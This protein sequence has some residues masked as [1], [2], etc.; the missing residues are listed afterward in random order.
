MNSFW[1]VTCTEHLRWN[2][3]VQ[4]FWS[5]FFRR[6]VKNKWPHNRY[7][8]TV[9]HLAGVSEK[10]NWKVVLTHLKLRTWSSQYTVWGRADWCCCRWCWRILRCCRSLFC[11][12]QRFVILFGVLPGNLPSIQN[13][14]NDRNHQNDQKHG[15]QDLFLSWTSSFKRNFTIF[16]ATTIMFNTNAVSRINFFDVLGLRHVAMFIGNGI[17]CVDNTSDLLW[18]E[19]WVALML[20]EQLVQ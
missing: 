15:Q 1:N 4:G 17:F 11:Y 7:I 8:I 19:F 3:S 2:C 10:K 6:A 18:Y 16:E 13:D 9:I 14:K 5:S 12:R 20:R